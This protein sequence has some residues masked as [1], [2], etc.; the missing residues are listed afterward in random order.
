L[1]RHPNSDDL[2]Y[3]FFNVI[4]CRMECDPKTQLIT[5]KWRTLRGVTTR[6]D[7]KASS[8]S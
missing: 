3:C 7:G 2:T 1:Y 4:I 5:E 8:I 6:F